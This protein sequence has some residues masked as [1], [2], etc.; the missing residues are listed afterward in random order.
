MP[1]QHAAHHH[2]VRPGPERLGDNNNVYNDNVYN[3]TMTYL[4]D[5]PRAST[6]TVGDDVPAQAVG[7]IRALQH[8]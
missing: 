6:A 4:G 1:S 8:S 3:M 2:K 5:I 7:R